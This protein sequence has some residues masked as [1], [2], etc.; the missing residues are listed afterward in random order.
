[1]DDE[2][3]R[4]K[5]EEDYQMDQEP[6]DKEHQ[7]GLPNWVMH[8]LDQWS[9]WRYLHQMD[10]ENYWMR[11]FGHG[12]DHFHYFHYCHY[13]HYHVLLVLLVGD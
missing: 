3:S 1:M 12:H 10:G 5:D 2:S 9:H 13:H 4:M 6:P 7:G 11:G 8:L